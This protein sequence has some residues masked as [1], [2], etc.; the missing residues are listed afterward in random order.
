MLTFF[1]KQCTPI[2]QE[3]FPCSCTR[4]LSFCGNC[5]SGCALVV[6]VFPLGL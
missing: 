3:K 5:G 2:F 6:G 1:G 4:Y